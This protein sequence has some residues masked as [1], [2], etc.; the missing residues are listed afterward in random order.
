VIFAR[1]YFTSLSTPLDPRACR[2]LAET[3]QRFLV[4]W[5]VADR[6]Q[7]FATTASTSVLGSTLLTKR[8]AYLTDRGP[9]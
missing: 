7:S 3:R 9:V 4:S 6:F 2:C 8:P 1:A 5:P